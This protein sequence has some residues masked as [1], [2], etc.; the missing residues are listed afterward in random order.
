[1]LGIFAAKVRNNPQTKQPILNISYAN[2]H[3]YT[4]TH[5]LQISLTKKALYGQRK[6]MFQNICFFFV[7]FLFLQKNDAH[8]T[9]IFPFPLNLVCFLLSKLG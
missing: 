1:M 4:K 8:N 6:K 2:P 3:F 5:L 7:F 9:D